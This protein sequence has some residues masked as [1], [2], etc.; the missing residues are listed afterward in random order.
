MS[1]AVLCRRV[2]SYDSP[3][4]EAAVEELFAACPAADALGPD[5]RV[6]VKPNLLAKHPPAHAVTTHP[7]VVAA[8]VRA[9][10]RR[11]VR[12][13][14]VADSP[15]GVYTPGVLRGIYAA[16]GM[17]QVCADTGA[18]LYTACRYEP[19]ACHGARVSAFQL[20]EPA[21]QADFIVDCPKVKTHVMTGLSCAVKNMFGTVPGL[22]KAELH[23]RFPQRGPFGQMLMDLWQC[24][25]PGL[26]VADGVLAM[27]GDGPA[28]GVPRQLGLILGGNDGWTVDLALCRMMGFEPCQV[29]YLAAGIEAG[30]CPPRFDTALLRGDADAL[31]PVPDWKRPSGFAGVDFSASVPRPVRWLVPGA[32]KLV[33]PRPK[34]RRDRCVGCGKCAEICPGHTI[35]VERG[36]AHIDPAGCI[37]CF[38]CHEMCPVKAIDVKRFFL[39]RM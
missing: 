4:L 5:S 10:Q 37:R 28:G 13:I 7:A 21:A 15:G 36:K 12:R 1:G 18:Q 32:E 9:L 3:A 17:A 23:M 30:L 34:I 31:A 19:V 8:C 26:V 29:P 22:Q 27:E 16:S 39:F 33:A 20:I 35:R 14:T 38:C 6:L 25:R 11:G 24:V 2:D